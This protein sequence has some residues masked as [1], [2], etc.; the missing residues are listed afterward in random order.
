MTMTATATKT[1]CCTPETAWSLSLVVSVMVLLC[2]EFVQQD[3]GKNKREVQ[4]TA[5]HQAI[6]MRVTQHALTI[7]VSRRRKIENPNSL[8]ICL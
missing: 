3:R 5:Q 1:G 2:V 6:C 8:R 4:S 7:C